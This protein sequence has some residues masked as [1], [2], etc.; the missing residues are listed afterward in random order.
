MT[1]SKIFY[2]DR[3]LI[4]CEKPIGVLS[5]GDESHAESMC[6]FVLERE[7]MRGEEP[8]V[9]V[10]HRLDRNV[11]GVMV[12]AKTKSAA[13][14]LSAAV[15]DKDVFVKEY[16][17]AVHGKPE[18]DCGVRNDYIAKAP[19]D[20]KVRVS[21]KKTKGAKEAS[22]YYRVISVKDALSLVYVRLYTGRTHQIRAQLAYHGTPIVGDKKYGIR[23]DAPNIALHAFRLSFPHPETGERLS[24][25]SLPTDAFPF[26]DKDIAAALE[27]AGI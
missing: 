8:Y 1:D 26:T 7:A 14:S 27:R 15:G 19:F 11:G 25:V 16:I 18:P 21:D 23:D 12:Y 24:A 6:D 17:A 3:A 22:L 13:A 2:E 9:G 5:Q 20:S 10:V 4:L